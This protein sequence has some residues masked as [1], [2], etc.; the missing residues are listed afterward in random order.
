MSK[1]CFESQLYYY[2]KIKI[3]TFKNENF[4]FMS[5][6]ELFYSMRMLLRYLFFICD[7]S[8]SEEK[9]LALRVLD[10]IQELSLESTLLR[11]SQS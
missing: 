2:P 4:E 5:N 6:S 8:V 9:T 10:G 11:F 3:D 7:Y 1:N